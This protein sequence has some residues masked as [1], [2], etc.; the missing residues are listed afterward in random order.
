NR[1]LVLAAL[2]EPSD[3]LS[4]SVLENAL[5][6]EDTEVM[7]DCLRRLGI[8]VE[9]DWE[10]RRI[11]ATCVPR[12]GWAQ[13]A[14]FFCGNSGTTMRFLTAMLAVGRGRYRLDGVRRLRERPMADLL[15]A[16]CQ[17]GINARS[18]AGNGCPP[19]IVEADGLRGG[20]VR[21][22]GTTSSQFISGL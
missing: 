21:I 16:L 22:R 15:D 19:I 7:V 10:N 18:E 13:E 3:T 2:S 12:S 1:A 14:E 20:E 8:P 11:I 17:L 4:A 6:S 5:L 9:A